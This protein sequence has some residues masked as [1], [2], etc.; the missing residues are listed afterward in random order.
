MSEWRGIEELHLSPARP[1]GGLPE[2]PIRLLETIRRYGPVNPVVVREVGPHDYEILSNAETW[3]AVQRLGRHQVPIEILEHVDDEQ[4]EAI[5]GAASEVASDD[6]ILEARYLAARLDDLG[7]RSRW[8]ATRR[9]AAVTG[10]SRTYISHAV[11]LLRLPEGIQDLVSAGRVSVGHAKALL[12]LPDVAAQEALARRVV[13]E[14]LSVRATEALVRGAPEGAPEAPPAVDSD[15]DP[16][17]VRLERALSETLGC[18]ARI[19]AGEGTLVLDYGG[20]LDVL[21]GV[22]WRLGIRDL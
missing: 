17:L 1:G 14:G 4:A 5:V 19:R 8:G 22:L 12:A 13:A 2:V 9:L 16:D 10:L 7:G 20:D 11:R 21:D 18:A 15:S 3:L 6:P